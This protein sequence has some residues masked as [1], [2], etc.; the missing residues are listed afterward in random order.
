ME[1]DMEFS[2]DNSL[3]HLVHRASQIAEERVASA[4]GDASL[5]PRQ[6]IVLAAIAANEGASQ[7]AIVE[8]TGVDRSTLADMVKRLLK[9]GL[10]SRRRTKEDAR[11]YAVKLTEA[12]QRTLATAVPVLMRIEAEMLAALPAKQRGELVAVLARLAKPDKA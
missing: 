6:I 8:A 9:R 2:A 1:T 11:A 5:T 3:L 12:G 7:T 4:L 10:L